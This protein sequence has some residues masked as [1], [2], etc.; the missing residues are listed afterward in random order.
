MFS[1][2]GAEAAC[3]RH[4]GKTRRA[5]LQRL[6]VPAVRLAHEIAVHALQRRAGKREA[7]DANA[8]PDRQR[9]PL[10]PGKRVGDALDR[11]QRPP[12][13]LLRQSEDAVKVN[14]R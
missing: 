6:D 11:D 1:P 14:L 3:Q 10:R 13:H 12:A 8:E 2:H 7:L 4:L 9:H 5:E